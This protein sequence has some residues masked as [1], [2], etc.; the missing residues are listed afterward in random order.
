MSEFAFRV[1]L[2]C[3]LLG[4]AVLCLYQAWRAEDG[5]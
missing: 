1:T 5:E 3:L 4:V 2:G